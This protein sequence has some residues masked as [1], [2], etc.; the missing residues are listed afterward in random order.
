MVI[1]LQ[2][3][4]LHWGEGGGIPPALPDTEKLGLFRVNMVQSSTPENS[5]QFVKAK[6]GT[7]QLR[8]VARNEEKTLSP[9]LTAEV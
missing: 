2:I 7:V 3:G 8:L 4:K 5:L 6:L 1:G 9:N